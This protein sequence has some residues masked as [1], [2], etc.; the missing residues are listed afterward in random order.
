VSECECAIY[1]SWLVV[2]LVGRTILEASVIIRGVLE[3]AI[4]LCERLLQVLRYRLLRM[5]CTLSV[6]QCW[7]P[8][9]NVEPNENE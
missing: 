7:R 5:V 2:R 9:V 6:F 8:I 1:K 4:R 3:G